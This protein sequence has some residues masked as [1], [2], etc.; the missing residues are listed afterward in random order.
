[1]HRGSCDECVTRALV[2]GMAAGLALG[3]L[4]STGKGPFVDTH[5]LAAA[6]W[7]HLQSTGVVHAQKDDVDTCKGAL[8]AL[9]LR[10]TAATPHRLRWAHPY[11]RRELVRVDKARNGLEQVGAHALL[12]VGRH[13]VGQLL[14]KA[15][16]AG[17]VGVGSGTALPA[18]VLSPPLLRFIGYGSALYEH[19]RAS[20]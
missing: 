5:R 13:M 19:L 12:S 9:W 17:W 3:R 15:K 1:M 4:T 14:R 6:T 16:G 11:Q 20:S 10:A 18:F 8:C 2:Q 7:A